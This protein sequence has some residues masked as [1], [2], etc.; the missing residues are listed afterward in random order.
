MPWWG[1]LLL[2]GYQLI[3][4]A[5]LVYLLTALWPDKAGTGDGKDGKVGNASGRGIVLCCCEWPL[6]DEGRL[7]L[8][9]AIAGALGSFVHTATSFAT[10]V[11][12]R[13]LA[14]SWTWW[15]VLR[16]PIGVSLALIF[17]CVTRGGLLS[18]GAS[19]NA[20]N[21]FGI[22]A[23]SGM[24]GM[25]SKQAADKLREVFDN[26]FRTQ[27]GQGD[28]QRMDKALPPPVIA[29][30]EPAS[31]PVGSTNLTIQVRGSTFA[32]AATVKVNGAERQTT[33]VSASQLTVTL[34][35]ADVAAAGTLEVSVV[36][37]APGGGTSA[38]KTLTVTG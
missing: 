38:P 10:Y 19:G 16:M 15:Y 30:L 23:A 6:S 21:P 37:P 4:A 5:V 20:L 36:N 29:A 33:Y 13:S 9:V 8:I 17:Y 3:L 28:D 22:A 27:Q 35:A 7:L 26:L 2:G 1:R 32:A 25:F 34:Q 24:V 12:N 14:V 18:A 11:G 31:L